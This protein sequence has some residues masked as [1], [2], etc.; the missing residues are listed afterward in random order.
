[1]TA[2]NRVT[3]E[4]LTRHAQYACITALRISLSVLCERRGPAR[5]DTSRGTAAA[6]G[7]RGAGGVEATV[8][9]PQVTHRRGRTAR[10]R[11][12]QS[13]DTD[14]I[15]KDYATRYVNYEFRLTR[16]RPVRGAPA[17]PAGAPRRTKAYSLTPEGIFFGTV[18]VASATRCLECATSRVPLRSTCTQNTC[19]RGHHEEADRNSCSVRQVW[20][21]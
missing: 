20:Q 2:A 16:A 15:F 14:F 8:P 3:A 1:M 19:G 5:P 4:P 13:G 11:G 6:G 9:H 12:K 17:G 21:R 7:R 10:A 18:R